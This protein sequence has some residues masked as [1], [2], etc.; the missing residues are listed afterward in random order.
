MKFPE[1]WTTVDKLNY[2]QRM[3]L[4]HSYI[5]YELNENVISDDRYNKIARLL[6]KKVQRYKDSSLMKKTMYGYVFNDFTEGS[7]GFNLIGKLKKKDKRW[8]DML[9]RQTLYKYKEEHKWR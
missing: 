4:I 2:L 6:N 9:A 1:S 7:S 3:I 5:Y 8:I